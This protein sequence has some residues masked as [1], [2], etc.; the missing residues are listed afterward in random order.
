MGACNTKEKD[1]FQ[2]IS[3]YFKNSKK[4]NNNTQKSDF[5]NFIIIFKIIMKE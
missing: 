3:T 2:S 4:I 1:E 5:F